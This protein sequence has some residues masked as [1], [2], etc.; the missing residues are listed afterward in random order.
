MSH[1]KKRP[2]MNKKSLDPQNYTIALLREASRLGLVGQ[3]FLDRFQHQVMTLVEGLMKRYTFGESSSLRVETA[4]SILMSALYSIDACLQAFRQPEAALAFLKAC[5]LDGVYRKGLE[6]VHSC[7]SETGRLLSRIN[8]G[9]LDLPSIAYHSTIDA[10]TGFFTAYDPIFRAQ[11]A[12]VSIDYPLLGDDMQLG[13]I[14]Y[15]RQYLQKLQ[16]ENDFCRLFRMQDINRLVADYGRTYRIDAREALINICELLLINSLFAFMSGNKAFE[17]GISGQQC[18]YLTSRYQGSDPVQT[19]DLLDQMLQGLLEGLSIEEPSMQHYIKSYH[20]LLLPRFLQALEHDTLDH[21]LVVQKREA[22]PSV[23]IFHEGERLDDSSFKCLVEQIL[24]CSEGSAK[25]QLVH[26]QVQ[27]TGDFID[28]LE[29]ECLFGEEFSTLFQTLGSLELSMLAS[30]V[31]AD[32]LRTDT[33]DLSPEVLS[34]PREK[35]WQYE[36][37]RYLISL[38]QEQR[39][40]LEKLIKSTWEARA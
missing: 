38:D 4:Q 6:R 21:L 18:R 2:L 34:Q 35:E 1:I 16:V 10:L 19:S 15:I 24:A 30:I 8:V 27:S 26:S 11:D 37:A 12:M 29:A 20:R 7:L 32:E 31:L 23:F 33:L 17:I 22:G 28:L 9:R 25:V 14:F 36:F 13:G 3:A 5:E 39:Q 40:N